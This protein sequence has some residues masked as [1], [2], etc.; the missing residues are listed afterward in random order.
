MGARSQ[1][2]LL[3]IQILMFDYKAISSYRSQASEQ[4]SVC[5]NKKWKFQKAN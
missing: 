4:N 3:I 1:V 2:Y 5:V